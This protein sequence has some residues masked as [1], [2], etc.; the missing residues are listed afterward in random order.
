MNP[1]FDD[2]GQRLHA[3]RRQ[4]FNSQQAFANHCREL[5]VPITRAIIADWETSRSGI[6]AQWIPFLAHALNAGVS[7]LL[8]N[9]SKA[10]I[11]ARPLC[12]PPPGAAR[13]D[14]KPKIMSGR[15]PATRQSA[16]ENALRNFDQAPRRFAPV[17]SELDRL[18]P[19][20]RLV[21]HDNRALLMALLRALNRNHRHVILLRY[22]GGLT[23][24]QIA[25]RLH[26]SVSIVSTRLSQGR[27][28]L[29]R[30]LNCDGG[31]HW[32]RS[33]FREQFP[34]LEKKS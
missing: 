20:D 33:E 2:P 19:F 32:L 26:R 17:N 30:L 7:D 18:N 34:P 24:R 9:F 14:S 10:A 27:E 29:R 15:A 8:P 3:L 1:P 21:W 5:G 11:L 13:K 16:L 23:I 4:F 31:R 6:P 12:L 22:Y 25:A 28:K